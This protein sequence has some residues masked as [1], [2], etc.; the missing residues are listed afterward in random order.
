MEQKF[1]SPPQIIPILSVPNFCKSFAFGTFLHRNVIALADVFRV[2]CPWK[3]ISVYHFY[4]QCILIPRT[5]KMPCS[6]SLP[7]HQI[8]Q[9]D[10]H[11]S[12]D[13]FVCKY[14][15]NSVCLLD[16]STDW[17]VDVVC[18]DATKPFWH[19]PPLPRVWYMIDNHLC[20]EQLGFFLYHNRTMLRL[21]GNSLRDVLW[22][23]GQYCDGVVYQYIAMI[24]HL[25]NVILPYRPRYSKWS[26][27]RRF[28]YQKRFVPLLSP[29]CAICPTLL[30]LLDFITQMRFGEE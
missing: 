29:I 22:N 9:S 28:F 6:S 15:S 20:Q 18:D 7:T 21:L 16:C 14:C 13:S 25:F 19:V 26:L 17:A 1:S 30:F 11:N 24:F 2:S 3:G 12:H 27:Y 8:L 10:A 5:H 4:L 23:Q